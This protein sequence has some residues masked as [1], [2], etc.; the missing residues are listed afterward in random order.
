[1]RLSFLYLGLEE[2]STADQNQRLR[3]GDKIFGLIE[4]FTGRFYWLDCAEQSHP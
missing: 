3:K 1:M 2:L 4:F